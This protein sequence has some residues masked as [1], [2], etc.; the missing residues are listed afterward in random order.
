MGFSSTSVFCPKCRELVTVPWPE[1]AGVDIVA[2]EI[3]SSGAPP[4]Q[5]NQRLSVR[6]EAVD[7]FH[8]CPDRS[9][10]SHQAFT[11][12]IDLDDMQA[13]REKYGNL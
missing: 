9:I 11:E 13:I 10:D 4:K 7:V 6:F 12:D 3:I 8:K 2:D 5:F 1:I